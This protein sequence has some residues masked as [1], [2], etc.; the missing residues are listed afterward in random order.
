MHCCGLPPQR[1][2]CSQHHGPPMKFSHLS[3]VSDKES[4]LHRS[5]QLRLRCTLRLSQP[6]GALFSLYPFGFISRQNH[7]GFS[8]QSLPLTIASVA[9]R[10]LLPLLPFLHLVLK[11]GGSTP[12]IRAL[13]RSAPPGR[14]YPIP[15]GHSSHDFR[16]SEV[17]LAW[18]R[19]PRVPPLMGFSP[20]QPAT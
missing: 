20:L 1:S 11:R 7:P 6:L 16:P 19:H 13:V 17:S 9:S 2:S 3:T 14:C 12:G 8:L 4:D 10:H 15:G 18:P 5:Y